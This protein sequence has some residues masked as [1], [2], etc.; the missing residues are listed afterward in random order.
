MHTSTGTNPDQA[1]LYCL[2]AFVG[3]DVP[4]GA[5][6]KPPFICVIMPCIAGFSSGT[7]RFSYI[8]TNPLIN[9]AGCVCFTA[10]LPAHLQHLV[11]HQLRDLLQWHIKQHNDHLVSFNY[12]TKC[13]NVTGA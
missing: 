11:P 1:L 7:I 13:H 5:Q 10:V 3:L 8:P 9:P 12:N 2:L 4:H 6:N